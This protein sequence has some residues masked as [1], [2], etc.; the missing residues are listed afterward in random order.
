MT[1]PSSLLGIPLVILVIIVLS[2]FFKNFLKI[3]T[4]YSGIIGGYIFSIT[5]IPL[6]GRIQIDALYPFISLF[7]AIIFYELG[8]RINLGWV[9]TKK[10]FFVAIVLMLILMFNIFIQA[11]LYFNLDFKSASLIS[12]I[13]ISTSPAFVL[14]SIKELKS[15]GYLTESIIHITGISN[16][17]GL[18]LFSIFFDISNYNSTA[19]FSSESVSEIIKMIIS[20]MSGFLTALMLN[21]V[22]NFF[23]F[24]ENTQFIV[25]SLFIV[26]VF[27]L[28]MQFN[29]SGMISLLTLGL[30]TKINNQRV[31]LHKSDLGPISN[32]SYLMIFIFA[33]Y[34]LSE[35]SFTYKDF[36]IA[37]ALISIKIFLPALFLMLSYKLNTL[38][39]KKTSL[40]SISLISLSSVAILLSTD[41]HLIGS[42][43]SLKAISILWSVIFISELI[44]P[45]LLSLGL[46]L[47][48]EVK[49]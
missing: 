10:L 41:L 30:F 33:G 26:T 28:S 34:H 14:Y 13:L 44:S 22:S 3:P 5:S 12:A 18:L 25:I 21:A 43:A 27:L 48:R 15:E 23:K 38:S 49:L 16:V 9:L 8:R 29:L 7:T 35:I 32:F 40:I 2:Q 46:K 31:N 20:C 24:D 37:S 4:I 47:S 6:I 19:I 17:L 1:I 45:I 42:E 11:L 36:F 39:F